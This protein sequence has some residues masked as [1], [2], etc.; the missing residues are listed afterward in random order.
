MASSNGFSNGMLHHDRLVGRVDP[1]AQ[2]N[3]GGIGQSSEFQP[4]TRGSEMYEKQYFPGQRKSLSGIASRA[5]ILGIVLSASLISTALILVLTTSALWRIPIFL[6]TLSLF[7][8]LEFW[9][10]ARYNTPEARVSSYLLS[11]NGSAYN[12]AHT[13][14]IFE[15][16]LVNMFFPG[17]HWLPSYLNFGFI[18]AGAVMIFVGQAI[19]SGA[20]VQAGT[21]FNHVVQHRKTDQH[22]LVTT[23]LYRYFRHPSY[24]GFYCWGL[25]TQLVLSNSICFLA[26][27]IILWKFFSSRISGTS[28]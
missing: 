3:A 2:I 27:A 24:F 20:M 25:G 19:R 28:N 6:A 4:L 14:A 17:R 21:N 10:T 18:I 8:F 26:Y 12:I 9:T 16:L 11:S 23:G 7:H 1:I 13:A 22:E 15:C 5:F